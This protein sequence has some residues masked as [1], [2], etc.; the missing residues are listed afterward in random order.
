M[1]SIT[2]GSSILIYSIIALLSS[3]YHFL[4][5]EHIH[6]NKLLMPGW[7]VELESMEVDLTPEIISDKDSRP[8]LKNPPGLSLIEYA[9]KTSMI[10][11]LNVNSRQ[12]PTVFISRLPSSSLFKILTK[13]H[14]IN[15]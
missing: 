12:S 13:F 14:L 15:N 1:L 8:S 4:I 3:Y 6:L 9:H 10:L 2:L 11:F 7:T 5:L